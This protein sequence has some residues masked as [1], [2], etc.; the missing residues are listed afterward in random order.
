MQRC[1][2]RPCGQK[3]VQGLLG[4]FTVTQ[5]RLAGVVL[6][7]SAPGRLA[8]T[9]VFI[10]VDIAVIDTAARRVF[11]VERALIESGIDGHRLLIAGQPGFCLCAQRSESIGLVFANQWLD[12]LVEV[13]F[14]H[15]RQLIQGEI[16]A[17][18]GDAALRVVIGT[19]AL[20]S[21]A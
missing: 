5:V 6:Q 4:A 13:T 19:D 10:Q 17:V 20:R 3:K 1:R 7:R 18:V 12:N 15:I 2:P 16:D 11:P 21:I 8:D 14:E 9:R